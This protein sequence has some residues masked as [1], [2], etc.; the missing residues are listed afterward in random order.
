MKTQR[1]LSPAARR[2]TTVCLLLQLLALIAPTISKASSVAS[3][4][5][6]GV[7]AINRARI[8]KAA[9]AALALEPVAITKCRAKLSEG[10]PN[11]SFSNG[12]YR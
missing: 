6:F 11:D 1:C 5:K 2:L 3:R 12:D 10:G 8:F 7:A 9:D 4:L